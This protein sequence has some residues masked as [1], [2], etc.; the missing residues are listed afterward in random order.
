MMIQLQSFF[1]A[2]FRYTCLFHNKFLLKYSISPLVSHKFKRFEFRITSHSLNYFQNAAKLTIALNILLPLI[3]SGIFFTQNS[4]GLPICL[5]EGYKNF[6]PAQLKICNY[7]NP[8]GNYACKFFFI[9]QV[10]LT[11]NLIDIYCTYFIS[12]MISSQTEAAKSLIGENTYISR[13]KYVDH[14][15]LIFYSIQVNSLYAKNWIL[16]K[17]E[18]LKKLKVG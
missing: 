12:K 10:I 14:S 5:G 3:S 1:N 13:K 6:F 8:I 16:D 15:Y 18:R 7:N 11:S 4:P 9:L 17:R 2:V